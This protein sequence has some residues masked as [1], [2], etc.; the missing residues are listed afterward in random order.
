MVHLES[1][2]SQV[3]Y[4]MDS[5]DVVSA[6]ICIIACIPYAC[7]LRNR[8]EIFRPINGMQH[9]LSFWWRDRSFQ[10]VLVP[11]TPRAVAHAAPIEVHPVSLR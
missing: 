8:W 2:I 9:D 6:A 5:C 11:L 4:D 3:P 1:A 7:D 10:D